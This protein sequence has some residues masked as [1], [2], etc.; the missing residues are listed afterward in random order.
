MGNS[1][2]DKKTTEDKQPWHRQGIHRGSP[3]W[4]LHQNDANRISE[5]LIKTYNHRRQH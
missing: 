2:L 1:D 3:R 5:F 4:R